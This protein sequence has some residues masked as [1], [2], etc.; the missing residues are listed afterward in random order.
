MSL[1]LG[2]RTFLSSL[3]AAGAAVL[4]P[5]R[6]AMAATT[7]A[8]GLTGSLSSPGV[9]LVDGHPIVT[10]TKGLGST[11][12]IHEEVGIVPVVAILGI[13]YYAAMGGRLG[14]AR[15]GA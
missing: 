4:A 10:I 7:A 8:K 13:S 11:G 6:L 2:R 3:G 12:N 14:K 5:Q 9:P 15:A 1:K